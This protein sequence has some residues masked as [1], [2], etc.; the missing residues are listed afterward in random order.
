M[1]PPPPAKLP[2]ADRD[3]WRRLTGAE[4]FLGGIIFALWENGAWKS[5]PE[6]T[7]RAIAFVVIDVIQT[8]SSHKSG[9]NHVAMDTTMFLAAFPRDSDKD[10]EDRYSGIYKDLPLV[11]T[12]QLH[13]HHMAP[14]HYKL[15][16]D[17][18][19]FVTTFAAATELA[20]Y[21]CKYFYRPQHV[22]PVED[23]GDGLPVEDEM[24]VDPEEDAD[25]PPA[26]H[27]FSILH[28]GRSITVP[29]FHTKKGA[30]IFSPVTLKQ[31]L[32][33]KTPLVADY[34]GEMVG[35]RELLDDDD[36]DDDNIKALRHELDDPSVTAESKLIPSPEAAT[37]FV[38][39]LKPNARFRCVTDLE[40][41][42]ELA[43]NVTGDTGATLHLKWVD[44]RWIRATEEEQHKALLFVLITI[45]GVPRPVVAMEVSTFNT[46]YSRSSNN[47]DPRY[48]MPNRLERV[49]T[50]HRIKRKEGRVA[51]TSFE[52]ASVCV[53][54]ATQ[55]DDDD[56]SE[57]EEDEDT[58]AYPEGEEEEESTLSFPSHHLTHS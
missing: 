56:S 32:G 50:N 26:H 54:W 47:F 22:P 25:A 39:F 34:T 18:K 2:P 1:P 40:Q 52:A 10:F 28:K 8:T 38:A 53:R 57:E 13:Y 19:M 17:T 3:E 36:L 35:A 11:E 42:K 37:A 9:Q 29:G 58:L 51:I 27:S 33:A 49:L 12:N 30:T 24:E 5:V 31:A 41:W 46:T 45:P 43:G 20:Q 15:P 6:T 44:N 16:E 55:V 23:E 4:P 14:R 48:G 7:P 21:E